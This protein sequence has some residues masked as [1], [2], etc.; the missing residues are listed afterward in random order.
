MISVL[1]L[2]EKRLWDK[3]FSLE[4]GNFSDLKYEDIV[5]RYRR[6]VYKSF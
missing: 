4:V 5:L 6:E 2:R 3:S 1:D